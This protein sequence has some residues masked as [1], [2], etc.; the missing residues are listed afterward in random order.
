MSETT[1]TPSPAPSQ[2]TG[3]G[4]APAA[5][6]TGSSTTTTT[7]APIPVVDM[8][9]FEGDLAAMRAHTTFIDT[10]VLPHYEGL[11]NAAR[12]AGM[13][14]EM[15]TRLTEGQEAVAMARAS[16][17]SATGA[18]VRLNAAV[19]QAHA[20]AAAAATKKSYYAGE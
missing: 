3:T 7:A 10:V 15:I 6:G 5:S 9:S 17:D 11:I 4:S 2:S 19:A 1:S 20:D 12:R 16:V 13:G 18:V 14:E 8:P